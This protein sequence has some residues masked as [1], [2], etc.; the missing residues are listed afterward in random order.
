MKINKIRLDFDRY[1]CECTSSHC[2]MMSGK[3]EYIPKKLIHL[4]KKKKKFAIVPK[5]YFEAKTNIQVED[6]EKTKFVSFGGKILDSH[7]SENCQLTESKKFPLRP[8]QREL[9]LRHIKSRYTAWVSDAGTGKTLCTATIAYSR[10][11]SGLIKHMFVMCPAHLVKQW[12]DL[13]ASYFPD[14][15]DFTVVSIDSASRESSLSKSLEKF[16]SIDGD[17]ELIIDES[18]YIKNNTAIRSKKLEKNFRAKYVQIATAFPIERSAGDLFYQFG[19]M[20]RD[21]IGCENYNQYERNFMILGGNDGER[22]VAYRHTKELK[23]RISPYIARMTF[24][25]VNDLIPPVKE[26]FVYFD[27]NDQQKQA[28]SAIENLIV[29]MQT[30]SGWLP[31]NKKY[32][33]DTFLHKVCSGYVPSEEEIN[34]TFKDF[35]NLGDSAENI[36]KIGQIAYNPYNNRINCLK[37]QLKI[38]GDKQVIIWC[39]YIDE[40]NTIKSMLPDSVVIDG[41]VTGKKRDVAEETFKEKKCKYLI[42]SIGINSGLNFNN[43]H[44]TIFFSNDYSR[45]KRENAKLR[46]QRADQTKACEAVFLIANNSL[47]I[48]IW[49]NAKHKNKVCDIFEG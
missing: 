45:T 17:I 46:I 7:K 5:W 43:C 29:Q 14:F 10:W 28:V 26:R 32:M 18:Q 48:R 9:C 6:I 31:E 11:V 1:L 8:K 37:E 42:I 22:I 35:G 39:K 3:K 2:V 27:M 40:I 33:I 23:E 24:S 4:L 34:T 38:M 44:K 13:V 47:D 49:E 12:N 30:T 16:N 19:V 36:T 25:E 21:I 20:N 41:S 15:K